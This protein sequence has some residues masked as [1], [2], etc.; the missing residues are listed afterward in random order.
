MPKQ[1]DLEPRE[2]RRQ[3]KAMRHL[4]RDGVRWKY[5]PHRLDQPWV[6]PAAIACGIW[7]GVVI[8]VARYFISGDNPWTIAIISLLP[9]AIFGAWLLWADKPD[10]Q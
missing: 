10:D 6:T 4:K 8:G 2:Y 3:P 7:A 1:I 9:G 5:I